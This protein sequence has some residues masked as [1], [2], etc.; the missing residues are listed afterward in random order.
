MFKAAEWA[1]LG[2]GGSN[3][4]EADQNRCARGSV[5]GSVADM[6]VHID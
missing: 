1:A 4:S 5:G 2:G 3:K 6:A